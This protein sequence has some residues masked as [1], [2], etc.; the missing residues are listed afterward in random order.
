MILSEEQ[1]ATRKFYVICTTPR[2]GS[3]LLCDLL[4]SSGVMGKSR[5]FLNPTGS[6]LP[7]S[8]KANLIDRESRININDYIQYIINNFSSANNCF[9]IKVFFEQIKPL[10]QLKEIQQFLQ[11]CKYVWLVRQDIIAQAVSMYIADET[12]TWKSFVKEKKSR[13]L[14]EYNEEKIARWVERLKKQNLNWA[15]FFLVN[16]IE[17]LKVTYE[18]IVI[19]HNQICHDICRFCGIEYHDRFSLENVRYQKQG[20]DLNEKFT[21]MFRQNSPINLYKTNEISQVDFRQIKLYS[22]S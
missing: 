21:E 19:N 8:K 5:E 4:S 20:D 14:V 9:G 16:R 10:V 22:L 15:D 1:T 13:N 2:S 3:N 17:Y 7:I 18:D 6:I 12:D 11:Q